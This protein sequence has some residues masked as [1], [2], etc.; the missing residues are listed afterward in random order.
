MA[1]SA[2]EARPTGTPNSAASGAVG[3]SVPLLESAIRV[4]QVASTAATTTTAATATTTATR[5][6]QDAMVDDA[7]AHEEFLERQLNESRRRERKYAL[8]RTLARAHARAM[9]RAVARSRALTPFRTN[10]LARP[11]A[12]TLSGC[13]RRWSRKAPP[14]ST[15][16]PTRAPRRRRPRR[17]SRKSAR[18][19]PTCTRR[20]ARSVSRRHL[21]GISAASRADPCRGGRADTRRVHVAGVCAV[22]ER[23]RRRA[24]RRRALGTR[25]RRCT[26]RASGGGGAALAPRLGIRREWAEIGRDRRRARRAR[27]EADGTKGGAREAAGGATEAS[28]R[29]GRA[30]RGE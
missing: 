2:D 28:G 12:P 15:C 23:A 20:C 30:S 17:C 10:P 16:R 3:K 27:E 26:G 11:P 22:L 6:A 8:A 13:T 9:T 18:R 24:S 29:C 14:Q 19:G 25:A 5:A 4:V 1:P 21:G 7:R